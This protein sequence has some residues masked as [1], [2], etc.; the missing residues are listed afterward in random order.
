MKGKQVQFLA[1]LAVVPALG[2]FLAIE[3]IL[4]ALFIAP[5]GAVDT[6]EHLVALISPP[7]GAGGGQKLEMLDF[8]G[9]RH[10]GSPA[11]IDKVILPVSRYVVVAINVGNDLQ[12]VVFPQV[13]K[14]L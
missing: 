11:Q 5:G 14:N 10:M 2:L 9:G 12:L 7:I 1:Q 13:G 8:T 6:L 4:Q 3:I